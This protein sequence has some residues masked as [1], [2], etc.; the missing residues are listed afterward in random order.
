MK[1]GNGAEPFIVHLHRQRDAVPTMLKAG[2]KIVVIPRPSVW[3][4]EFNAQRDPL[5]VRRAEPCLQ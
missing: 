4:E 3:R 2:D 1:Y 5:T